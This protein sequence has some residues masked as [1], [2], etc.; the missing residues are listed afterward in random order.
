MVQFCLVQFSVYFNS[1]CIDSIYYRTQQFCVMC[2]RTLILSIV[3]L[4]L[5]E[6][7]VVREN[8]NY[9]IPPTSGFLENLM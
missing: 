7:I 6:K 2:A 3:A 1:A 4:V 5:R 9:V 8:V